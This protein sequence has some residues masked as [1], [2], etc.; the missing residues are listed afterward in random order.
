MRRL[1]GRWLFLLLTLGCGAQ[2]VLPALR[3]GT[4]PQLDT[5]EE[6]RAAFTQAYALFRRGDFQGALPT[7]T[8]LVS[9]Y[10]ELP[11]YPLYFAGVAAVRSQRDA[12]AERWLTRLVD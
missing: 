12:D 10:P 4:S 2:S 1:V 7:F 8:A 6:R 3:S 9:R 5:V 11:D